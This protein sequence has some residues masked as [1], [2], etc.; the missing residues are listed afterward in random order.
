M[1]LPLLLTSAVKPVSGLLSGLFGGNSKDATRIANAQAAL[2][3]ALAGDSSAVLLMQQGAGLIPGYGSATAVGKAAFQ[4]ALDAYNA[5]RTTFE[6]PTTQPSAFQQQVATT[7]AAVRNEIAQGLQNLG[8]GATTAVSGAVG[9]S[10]FNPMTIPINR[11]QAILL[12][13]IAGAILFLRK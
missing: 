6:T 12:A 11:D 10:A 9:T 7:T 13:V 5:Q 8:A 3:R 2:T 1:P 4:A